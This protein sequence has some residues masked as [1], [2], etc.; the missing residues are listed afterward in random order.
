MHVVWVLP[1]PLLSLLPTD[2]LPRSIDIMRM[3]EALRSRLRH[4]CD[5]SFLL[6]PS[7][8][9]GG[10]P[11]GLSTRETG[12]LMREFLGLWENLHLPNHRTLE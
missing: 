11:S 10:M 5:R 12:P 4:M 6:S 2:S 8:K 3:N 1:L 9:T 7:N